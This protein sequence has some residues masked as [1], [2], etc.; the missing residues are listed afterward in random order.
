[1]NAGLDGQQEVPGRGRDREEGGIEAGERRR[2]REDPERV[3]EV[4]DV[5]ARGLG[6]AADQVE[7][8]LVRIRLAEQVD[9]LG[10]EDV[11][12]KIAAVLFREVIAEAR[13][14]DAVQNPDLTTVASLLNRRAA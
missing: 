4:V 2:P 9:R 12:G 6:G 10:G 1:V 7:E 8:A 3:D 13:E 14:D 11:P 5:S